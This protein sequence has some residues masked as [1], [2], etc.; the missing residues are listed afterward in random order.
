MKYE[1]SLAEVLQWKEEAGNI[2]YNLTIQGRLKVI[3]EGAKV[4]LSQDKNV[5]I[6]EEKKPNPSLQRTVKAI[7]L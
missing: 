2:L 3:R 7:G 5:T 6:P 4:R 1:K